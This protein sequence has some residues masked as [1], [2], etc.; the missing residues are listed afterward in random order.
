M[1]KWVWQVGA[2][3]PRRVIHSMK[4]G[5]ALSLVS[6]LDFVRPLFDSF[7]GNAMWVVMTVVVVFEFTV[8]NYSPKY[9]QFTS[10]FKHFE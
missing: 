6:I 10:I 4:V 8:G 3:D 7:G 9:L 1:S 2:D 5:L